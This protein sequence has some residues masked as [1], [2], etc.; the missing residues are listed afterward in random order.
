[1]DVW[2]IGQ[3]QTTHSPSFKDDLILNQVYLR[4]GWVLAIHLTI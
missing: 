4:D 3:P 2:R 1:M